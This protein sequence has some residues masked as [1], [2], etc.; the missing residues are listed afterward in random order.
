[1]RD[2]RRSISSIYPRAERVY[3]NMIVYRIGIITR[4]YHHHQNEKHKR[5][6]NT[7]AHSI[8]EN[9][10]IVPSLIVLYISHIYSKQKRN[11][12]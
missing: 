5:A 3:T 4:E 11:V 2:V 1:M 12:Y 10:Q 6:I 9:H 8:H 7:V